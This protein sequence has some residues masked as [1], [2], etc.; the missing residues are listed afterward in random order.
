MRFKEFRVLEADAGETNPDKPTQGELDDIAG[1]KSANETLR[2][3]PPYPPEQTEAVKA[4]QSRLEELGYSVGSTGIDGKYGSR[5]S[6]AVRAFKKDNNLSGDGLSMSGADLEKLKTAQKVSNPT[7]T[8]NIRST[9]GAAT[10]GQPG[11]LEGTSVMASN[12]NTNALP[13]QN[14]IDALDKAASSLGIQVQI[15]PA[16]GR[17]A[18]STGTKNHPAGQAADI[19]IVKDGN[20]ITTSQ[21]SA[22]YDKLITTLVRNAAAKGVRP[23]IGGY[24]WGIHYDESDW[25]QG[26]SGSIA[27]T[28]DKGY[29]VTP[30]VNK[31]VA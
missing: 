21:D 17:A 10:G 18:R 26:N 3:G 4:M 23:G 19:Q 9:G 15:T 13:N 8:G 27:G 22:M 11:S 30:A 28:W 5:T 20:I 29:D 6:S 1:A 14:I 24:S 2:S 12:P 16:G 25:R 31:A 7:P